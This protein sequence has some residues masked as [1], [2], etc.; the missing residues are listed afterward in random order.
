[1]VPFFREQRA[2]AD[3]RRK[4]IAILAQPV[5]LHARRAHPRLAEKAWLAIAMIGSQPGGQQRFHRSADQFGAL[6]AKQPFRVTVDQ[7]DAARAVD[8]HDGIGRRF[9]QIAKFGFH[10]AR[11]ARHFKVGD[12]SL[13]RQDKSQP[14]MVTSRSAL[15]ETLTCTSEPSLR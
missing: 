3:F 11:V 9:E 5:E 15:L 6:V 4:L 10:Q 8:D 7:N 2:Q 13:R 1:M 12:V 14:A